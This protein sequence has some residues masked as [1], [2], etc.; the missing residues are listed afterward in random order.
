MVHRTGLV[1]AAILPRVAGLGFWQRVFFGV[2]LF[3]V[4]VFG[5][6]SFWYGGR[7]AWIDAQTLQARWQVNLW[8]DRGSAV[9]SSELWQKTVDQLSSAQ[10]RSP[11]N[12]QLLDDLGF[13]FAKAAQALG[14]P[15]INSPTY[16]QQ[17]ALLSQA[18]VSYRAA[19]NLRPTFPY[20]W[21]YLALAKQ[22]HGELDAEYWLAF[23][24]GLQ[25]G[26]S[27]AGVQSTLAFMAF[28]QWDTLRTD[29][30]GGIV[31]MVTTAHPR[32][33]QVLY[34][35]AAQQHVALPE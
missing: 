5:V 28:S 14:H 2:V 31:R 32:S 8:R 24:K 6:L 7:A 10:V 33:R 29:R 4:L 20:T 11:G 30:K 34:E 17:H 9:G 12:A 1:G 22:L 35:M 18:I 25:L 3:A 16:V 21:A 26:G 13:L 27:E 19:A 23:D 15:A